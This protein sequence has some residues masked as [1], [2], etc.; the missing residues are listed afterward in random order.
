MRFPK[1]ELAKR[2]YLPSLL[3]TW[4]DARVVE[5]EGA[6]IIATPGGFVLSENDLMERIFNRVEIPCDR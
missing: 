2:Y 4:P 5:Y 6:F 3:K 1:R